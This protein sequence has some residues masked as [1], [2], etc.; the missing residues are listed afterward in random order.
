[1]Q[2]RLWVEEQAAILAEEDRSE[3]KA[4]TRSI[5]CTDALSMIRYAGGVVLDAD[6]RRRPSLP[7]SPFAVRGRMRSV[8]GMFVD[9]SPTLERFVLKFSPG[10]NVSGGNFDF[11]INDCQ[12]KWKL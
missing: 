2:R 6:R 8:L 1:M 5:S 12:G 10:R 3:R 4:V 11:H 9:P 7:P